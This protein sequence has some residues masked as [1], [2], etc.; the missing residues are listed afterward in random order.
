VSNLISAPITRPVIARARILDLGIKPEVAVAMVT[1]GLTL[2]P[3]HTA[4]DLEKKGD[5]PSRQPAPV[6]S[7]ARASFFID[8]RGERM[9]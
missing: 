6:T 2:E 5:R 8:H 3:A 9:V 7:R 1:W 4:L